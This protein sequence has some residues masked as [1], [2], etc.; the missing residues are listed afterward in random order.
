V[1]PRVMLYSIS[2]Q[3]A[4]AHKLLPPALRSG[5]LATKRRLR[6]HEALKKAA[7]EYLVG[8]LMST[9]AFRAE[10]GGDARDS[11]GENNDKA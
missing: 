6:R 3:T 10:K 2:D 4:T 1:F 7:V 9:Q 5:D 8:R 11:A